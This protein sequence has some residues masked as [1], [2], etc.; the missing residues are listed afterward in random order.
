MKLTNTKIIHATKDAKKNWDGI[1]E[2][3]K[4]VCPSCEI[5]NTDKT[6]LLDGE[7]K[8]IGEEK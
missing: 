8:L 5:D 7:N 3:K 1:K 4:T 2:N 6:I